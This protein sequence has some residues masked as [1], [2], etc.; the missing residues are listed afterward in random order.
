MFR[1]SNQTRDIDQR[2]PLRQT[3]LRFRTLPLIY[4]LDFN[5]L[6]DIGL[7]IQP[8]AFDSTV[9]SR[10]HTSSEYRR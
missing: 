6:N 4:R 2:L 3:R 5:P 1:L 7:L 10:C 9:C 8:S